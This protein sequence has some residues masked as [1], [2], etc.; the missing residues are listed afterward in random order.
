[1]IENKPKPEIS[2]EFSSRFA[3]RKLNFVRMEDKQLVSL[4]RWRSFQDDLATALD[5]F[6]KAK[7]WADLIKYLQR[8]I[9]VQSCKSLIS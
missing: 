2:L 9:K 3:K 4:P 8:V 1:M 7:E 5:Q 6:E